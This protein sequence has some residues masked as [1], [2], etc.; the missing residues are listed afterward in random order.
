MTVR[1][2]VD[3]ERGVARRVHSFTHLM[4][5]PLS[6]REYRKWTHLRKLL[7]KDTPRNTGN[8]PLNR[9]PERRK[10][11][12]DSAAFELVGYPTRLLHH[13][14]RARGSGIADAHLG[15]EATRVVPDIPEGC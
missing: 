12:G 7:A 11:E 15:D 13:C 10:I 6:A 3:G 1:G 5:L 2:E 9:G 14:C 8:E 4:S